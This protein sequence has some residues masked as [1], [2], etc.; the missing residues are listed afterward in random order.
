MIPPDVRTASGGRQGAARAGLT[1]GGALRFGQRLL[2]LVEGGDA[3]A[4][5]G[6]GLFHPVSGG[7]VGAGGGRAARI[8]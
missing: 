7:A 2:V 5:E 3:L 8:I 4:A 6:A 1:D